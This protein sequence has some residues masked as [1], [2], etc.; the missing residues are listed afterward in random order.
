M[1]VS[2][3]G[4]GVRHCICAILHLTTHLLQP[5]SRREGKMDAAVMGILSGV[6]Y[7][8]GIDYYKGVNEEYGK[9]VGSG[10]GLMPRNPLMMMVSVDCDSYAKLLTEK[11]WEEVRDHLMVGVDKL[12]AAG[13]D[14]LVLASNTAHISVPRIEAK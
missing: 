1:T 3:S 7:V 4:C 10:T 13:V 14:F 12:V 9:L 5:W 2:C 11:R 6:S 8:S